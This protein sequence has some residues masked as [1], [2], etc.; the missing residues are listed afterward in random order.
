MDLSAGWGATYVTNARTIYEV[1]SLTAYLDRYASLWKKDLEVEVDEFLSASPTIHDFQ[2]KFEELDAIS[3][4][5]DEEPNHYVTY[6]KA[7]IE[8]YINQVENIGNLLEEWDRNLQRNINNLDDIAFIMDTL[9]VIREKEIDTDRE[10]IQCEE[11]NA[12]LSKFDLPYPKDIGDR[13]ES[14]RCAFLRIKE[15][16]F[17]TTDHILSI[18]GGYKDGLLESIQELK[19]STKVFESDYDEVSWFT[20]NYCDVLKLYRKCPTNA[21]FASQTRIWLT[22]ISKNVTH[23][24]NPQRYTVIK[25]VDLMVLNNF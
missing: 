1:D 7:F 18:Q 24:T 6:V 21:T 3:R 14:V 11:A 10:L 2:I 4:G 19:E 8:R 20:R 25:S 22:K 23:L 13:V 16:V 17:F 9:R 12:L 5:L 15:R